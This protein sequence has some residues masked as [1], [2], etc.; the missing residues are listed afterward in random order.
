MT[1]G[2]VDEEQRRR[3]LRVLTWIGAFSVSACSYNL[4]IWLVGGVSLFENISW[5]FPFFAMGFVCGPLAV[6]FIS[7]LTIESLRLIFLASTCCPDPNSSGWVGMAAMGS[8]LV[9]S[10]LSTYLLWGLMRR[11]KRSALFAVALSFVLSGLW[12]TLVD[13]GEG[14]CRRNACPV[15]YQPTVFA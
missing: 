4:V 12:L 1:T 9:G 5:G 3:A 8:A 7:L 13:I 15:S 11:R 2:K 14:A 6:A 10:A